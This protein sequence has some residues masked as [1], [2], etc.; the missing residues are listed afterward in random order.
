LSSGPAVSARRKQRSVQHTPTHKRRD[1]RCNQRQGPKSSDSKSTDSDLG[2]SSGKHFRV[3]Q[4]QVAFN[5]TRSVMHTARDADLKGNCQGDDM[6]AGDGCV[7]EPE[8]GPQESSSSAPPPGRGPPKESLSSPP[9][10]L[11][12]LLGSN[13]TIAMHEEDDTWGQRQS[14]HHEVCAAAR[15]SRPSFEQ[16]DITP[17]KLIEQT[18]IERRM[19]STRTSDVRQALRDAVHKASTRSI[20]TPSVAAEHSAV[21]GSV[22][23]KV[24]DSLRIADRLHRPDARCGRYAKAVAAAFEA[25]STEAAARE[26]HL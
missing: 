18:P 3:V 1:Q 15:H 10:P 25:A 8:P 5:A 13:S 7:A 6:P 14:K 26:R 16:G 19:P 20:S 17:T 21:V 9:L 12:G 23:E 22:R 24:A 2:C 4:D 11:C